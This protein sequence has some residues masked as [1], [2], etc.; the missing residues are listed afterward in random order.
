M[1]TTPTNNRTCI[2][3]FFPMQVYPLVPADSQCRAVHKT[4][5]CAPAHQA[6]LQEQDEVHPPIR[7]FFRNRMNGTITFL[8]NSVNLL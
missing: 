1:A 2:F 4:Y 6:L 7:H 8:S 5:P 3:R